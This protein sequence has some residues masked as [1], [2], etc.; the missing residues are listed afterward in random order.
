MLSPE[1]IRKAEYNVKG[2]LRNGLIKKIRTFDERILD[3]YIEKSNES[4][5]VANYLFENKISSL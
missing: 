5:D 1:R 4:L 3:A 2:Y